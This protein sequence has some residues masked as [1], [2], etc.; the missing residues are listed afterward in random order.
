[1]TLSF[2]KNLHLAVPDFLTEPWH[3][4]FAQAMD[5]IDEIVFHALIAQDIDL[6]QN[7]TVYAIGSL[8]ISPDTGGI[9]SAAVA[10][11]S[12]AAPQTFA[13]E[14][15]DHPTFWTPLGLRLATQA[16]AEAGIDNT[17]YMTPL[18]VAQAIDAQSPVSIASKSQAEAGTD[19]TQL[20]TPLRV[21][22]H[23]AANIFSTGDAKLTFKNVADPSWIMANDG[24]I[25]NGLSSATTRADD[26]TQALFELLYNN[27]TFTSAQTVTISIAAPAVITKAA[28]GLSINQKVVFSTTGTLPNGITAGTPYF[29]ISAGFNINSFQVSATM[30][31]SAVTTTGAQA[32]IHTAIATFD[33]A[34]QDNTG[35][36][37]AR[38]ANAGADFT[39]SRRLVVPVMLG[40]ALAVAGTG[41]GLTARHLGTPAGAETETQTVAKMAPHSHTTSGLNGP[42]TPLSQADQN[43]NMTFSGING[44]GG[45]NIDV[46]GGGQPL[47]IMQPT[48]FLNV[49]IKL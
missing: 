38:G 16:E 34:L 37:V 36:Q 41:A 15:I 31:G 1:M 10:H 47:S 21:A 48:Q 45:T 24:S 20:M 25:G 19:N 13:Q 44:V 18:R 43:Q 27:I 28:H 23:M 26:D 12:T 9:F 17:K 46:S 32:G 30:S 39:A 40:R 5:S 6:W 11:T 4:E 14:Q 33:L 22:Q 49:M 7:S 8:V 2:T 29:I 3:S 42:T 35:T